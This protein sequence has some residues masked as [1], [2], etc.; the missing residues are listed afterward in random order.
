MANL[1]ELKDLQNEHEDD[2]EEM[3][4]T[5]REQEKEIKKFS[6]ILNMLMTQD[7]IDHVVNNSEWSE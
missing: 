6:A 3:L 7:Q 4:D 1:Q 5:I 2:K